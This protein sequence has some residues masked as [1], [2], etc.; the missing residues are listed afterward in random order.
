MDIEL[1]AYKDSHAHVSQDTVNEFEKAIKATSVATRL[2]ANPTKNASRYAAALLL[3]TGMHP[4]TL[5]FRSGRYHRFAVLMGP[6]FKKVFFPFLFNRNN[7]VY[8]FDAWPANHTRIEW[9]I[10]SFR[11]KHVFFSSSQVTELF[12]GKGLSTQFHWVPEGIDL[13]DYSSRDY[14]AKDIDVLSFGRKYD[15]LHNKIVDGLEIDGISYLYEKEKGKII[16]PDRAAFV[17]G[18]ARTKVSICVPSAITHPV[19][20]G[21]IQTMTIRYLQSMA[22]RTLIVGLMPE[23]M[24]RLFDHTPVIEVDKKDPLGQIRDILAH[25]S[26]HIPLIEKNYQA[27]RQ[28]HTWAHRW[29]M[30]TGVLGE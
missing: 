14:A 22:A 2:I 1:V 19:R 10:R 18:L 9:F 11:P 12:Q 5:P 13:N 17:D 24:K 6:E 7:S 29:Q 25:F 21:N 23:E 28:Q 4:P 16:F 3:K 27:V 15:E 8:F 26:D 30:I 20:S